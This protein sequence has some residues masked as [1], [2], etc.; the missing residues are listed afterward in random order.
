MKRFKSLID[1]NLYTILKH[2][3]GKEMKK[4]PT[5][6]EKV[7]DGEKY[8]GV[9]RNVTPGL[10][11]VL[12]GEGTATI[13]ID[14]SCCAIINGVFYKRYDAKHGKT[15]PD[16]AIPCC[17]P[18]PITGHWPHWIQVDFESKSNK[19]I[20]EAYYNAVSHGM[21]LGDGTYEACGKHFQ[22]NPYNMPFDILVPHGRHEIHALVRTFDGI[23][24]W[25]STHEQEGIVFWK[26]GEPQCK[27][28]R[29]DFGFNWPVKK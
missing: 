15:P 16:G 25:L 26:D 24:E 11:W 5:L 14:G 13:K 28:K 21:A 1:L 23:K 29:R 6:F 19:W 17:D 7:Y 18:D 3:E 12:N 20:V 22:G 27:I 4:I 8:M 10:E 9:T 2:H